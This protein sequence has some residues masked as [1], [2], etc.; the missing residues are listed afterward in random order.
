MKTKKIY[1]TITMVISMMIFAFTSFSQSVTISSQA[2]FYGESVEV[3][4]YGFKDPVNV[5]LYRG[6]H[7]IAYASTNAAGGGSQKLVMTNEA[8]GTGYKLSPGIDYYV[9]VELRSNTS[10]SRSTLNFSVSIPSLKVEPASAKYG[11]TVKLT[12]SG[13][14]SNINL[15]FMDN[16]REITDARIDAPVSGSQQITLT[17]DAVNKPGY[18]LTSGNNYTIKAQLRS[19]P[20][21]YFSSN[22]FSISRTFDFNIAPVGSVSLGNAAGQG[23][24]LIY[25]NSEWTASKDQSWITFTSSTTGKGNGVVNWQVN[26]NTSPGIRTGA[27]TITAGG[28]SKKLSIE[29]AGKSITLSV[30][31]SDLV[32]ESS[33]GSHSISVNSNAG[34]NTSVT[35]PWIKILSG[36]NGWYNGQVVF[37]VAENTSSDGRSGL[38]EVSTP[39]H[40]QKQRVAIHQNG[41]KTVEKMVSLNPDGVSSIIWPFAQ[42]N[43]ANPV[44]WKLTQGK[45]SKISGSWHYLGDFYAQDWGYYNC[46]D[47]AF[48]SPFSGIVLYTGSDSGYGKHIVIQSLE[49]HEFAFR[50]AHLNEINVSNGQIVNA[51]QKVGVV[52]NTGNSTGIHAHAVLYKNIDQE[53]SKGITG[54]DLLKTGRSLGIAQQGDP[55]AFAADFIFDATFETAIG[56]GGFPVTQDM[57]GFTTSGRFFLSQIVLN[58]FQVDKVLVGFSNLSTGKW[59]ESEMELND[60]KFIFES[61]D[62]YAGQREYVFIILKDGVKK[63]LPEEIQNRIHKKSDVIS[64][65]IGGMNF[66]TT[67]IDSKSDIEDEKAM[68]PRNHY[69]FTYNGKFFI[70]KSIPNV[71]WATAVQVGYWNY[72]L[73][74]W[75][76][77]K[78]S[79]ENDFWIFESGD[80]FCDYR[81]YI[82][83]IESPSGQLWLPEAIKEQ[84]YHTD[85]RANGHGGHNFFT[86]SSDN[87][88]HPES[89]KPELAPIGPE[90]YGFTV[91]G[92]FWVSAVVV[93]NFYAIEKVEVGFW[94][95]R[96]QKWLIR[97]MSSEGKQ[98]RYFSG[99]FHHTGFRDYVFILHTQGVVVYLPESI[100]DRIIQKQDVRSNNQGGSSFYTL[101]KELPVDTKSAMIGSLTTSIDV[102]GQFTSEFAIFP[103]PAVDKIY[104]RLGNRSERLAYKIFDVHG[105]CVQ[106]DLNYTDNQ[107][108][109][110]L[111]SGLYFLE[112]I[113]EDK[114]MVEKFVVR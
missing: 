56:G 92:I 109:I 32:L 83:L 63:Y 2:V 52:G 111:K 18:Q 22:A 51:G 35:V 44:G 65:G 16:G 39:Y 77:Q 9:K 105:R 15:L 31:P 101:P 84:L 106:Q 67:P 21:K 17:D 76:W 99:D 11:E 103:N 90:S 20:E 42:G 98:F 4:W 70:H 13:F 69:G 62:S 110:N 80:S 108:S 24:I 19:A 34:W 82:F 66:R 114:K 89:G 93:D 73:G 12:W 60:S 8:I 46:P 49:C 28:N 81:D 43:Y 112:I 86:K 91:D 68:I 54:V 26:E 38:I 5:I 27:I 64:N 59:Q 100:L 58:G 45:D 36:S 29:Q 96:E 61:K 10:V 72:S 107:I 88:T 48:F 23:Q 47:Y 50:V 7:L 79:L 53:F 30:S 104:F 3:T 97:E 87:T 71:F 78:M 85:I 113:T 95:F 40:P 57:Y 75:Q 1:V 33:G 74:Q 37:S 25:A 102:S 14:A 41:M 94:S 6:S 55:N